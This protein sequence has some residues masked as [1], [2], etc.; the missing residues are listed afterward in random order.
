M[1]NIEKCIIKPTKFHG[2]TEKNSFSEDYPQVNQWL[3][4][5]IASGPIK[6]GV[7]IAKIKMRVWDEVKYNE[8]WAD[9][10]FWARS[11]NHMRLILKLGITAID[12]LQS[13]SAQVATPLAEA[14]AV[15]YTSDKTK[16]QII[17]DSVALGGV[18]KCR[19]DRK[20]SMIGL[21]LTG[22]KLMD[23]LAF[24]FQYLNWEKEEGVDES[25]IECQ[26]QPDI[27]D[28]ISNRK[29]RKLDK[30]L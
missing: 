8:F 1:P 29:F 17:S 25:R 11:I 3:K 5:N 14:K 27:S 2:S 16:R 9:N 20:K 18:K 22:P 6:Y 4:D 21:Y 23:F 15:M 7:S 12:A 24:Q 26:N 30:I 10:L 28:F 13:G 19:L